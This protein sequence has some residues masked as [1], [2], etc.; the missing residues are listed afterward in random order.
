MFTYYLYSSDHDVSILHA[1]MHTLLLLLDNIPQY[2]HSTL[3]DQ[4]ILCILRGLFCIVVSGAGSSFARVAGFASAFR[5]SC[6]PVVVSGRRLPNDRLWGCD[7]GTLASD[8]LWD[9]NFVEAY[10]SKR[11]AKQRQPPRWRTQNV[12]Y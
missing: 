6:A 10:L 9:W 11:R 2:L 12:V 3:L 5:L 1:P 4:C 7:P 8:V